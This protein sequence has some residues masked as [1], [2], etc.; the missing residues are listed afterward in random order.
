MGI[1]IPKM[2]MSKI[3]LADALFSRTQQR[4][5]GLLFRDPGRSYYAN[6][7][8]RAARVGTGTIQRQ[9]ETLTAAGIVT[10]QRTGNQKHYQAN[11]QSPVFGELY[12][13]VL[14]TVGFAQPLHDALKPLGKK[15]RVA[16]IYGSMA[17]DTAQTA[18]D[19]DLLL[20]GTVTLREA[21]V[22]LGPMHG[23]LGREINPV[24]LTEQKFMSG[25]ESKDRFISRLIEEPKIFVKGDQRDF[26]Q[27]AENRQT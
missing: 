15:V 16:F 4:V 11:R 2:G 19:I 7:I 14:K 1:I 22:R 17:A 3:S 20:I 5:L 13:L 9:L 12:S 6:E 23:M 26:E 27:L 25:I 21:A 8:L 18:S 10:A 24:V